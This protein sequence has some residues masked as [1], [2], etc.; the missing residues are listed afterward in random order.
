[1]ARRLSDIAPNLILASMVLITVLP[2]VSLFTTALQP[3]GTTPNGLTIPSDPQWG[4]FADAWQQ[5][6]FVTLLGSTTVIVLGVVPVSV[7]IAT[8]AGYAL[9]QLRVP[10]G[11]VAYALLV[12]GLTLPA[13]AIMTP[14][15]LEMKQF[16]L[17]DSQ[18]AL[19]LPL[20][21]LFM[22]F[23]VTWM[24]THF[25][26]VPRELTEAASIDG[27]GA[28]DL[29]RRIHVPL[30]VPAWT[31]LAM[32]LFLWTA[33]Q[34]MLA[35]VMITDPSQ[36]TLAGALGAFQG[37]RT[38]NVVLLCAASLLIITPTTLVFLVAQRQFIRA[39]LQGIEK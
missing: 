18:I 22:P 20:I 3:Q 29:F 16:H 25:A 6:N 30:A 14:L 5:S 17:L 11:G 10:G 35:I 34:F 33:N 21:G 1:M 37:E 36:R 26:S 27:A 12:F 4:N 13:P 28:A 2:L 19:I 24:R 31:S 9:A 7:L 15:Y 32:L 38:T 8:M 39:L 23:S